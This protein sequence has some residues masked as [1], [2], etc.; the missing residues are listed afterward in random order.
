MALYPIPVEKTPST[1]FYYYDL[2]L[3]ERTLRACKE[4]ADAHHYRVHYAMKANVEQPLLTAIAAAGMGAD[5]VSGWEVEA[6][7]KAGFPLSEI[8]FAG[9]GKSDAE[10][11][12][13]L[14]Q[15]IFCFNCESLEELEVLNGLALQ[16]NRTARVALRLNPDVEPETHKYIATGGAQSKFGISIDEVKTALSRITDYQG[17]QIVGLHFH[18]GSG[19][20][21]FSGFENLCRKANHINE[22]LLSQGID[23]QH[24]NMG[25]G[26]GIDYADPDTGLIPDFETFFDIFAQNLKPRKGQTVHFELGRSLVGQCGELLTR[27]LF[28]K[29]TSS[30]DKF[31]IVDAGM[32]ELIRPALYSA[33]HRIEN[34][35]A[36][37][38]ARLKERYSIGGPICESSDIFAYDIEFPLSV[39][40]DLLAIRSCGAYGSIMSS[41]YNLRP[42]APAYFGNGNS[43]I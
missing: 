38:E 28:T 26:L 2:G 5:C 37:N 40:G 19:I 15:D 29:T 43:I 35:T 3:L 6:A 21:N 4:Q 33:K 13:A 1:P 7:I 25:G 9:V 14:D 18:I 42:T 27:V 31:L 41:H 32:T 12:Y 34:L 17:I 11:C 39:R 23:L 8:V 36:R 22:W 16:K 20:L 10:I 30:G 24:L